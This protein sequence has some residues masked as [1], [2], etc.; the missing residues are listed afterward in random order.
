MPHDTAYR[1]ESRIEHE[2]I[3]SFDDFVTGYRRRFR[4]SGRYPTTLV[5][6]LADSIALLTSFGIGFFIVNAYDLDIINFK[7]FVSYWPYLPAFILGFTFAHLYPGLILA[8]AEEFRRFWI[9]S[10]MGHAGIVLTLYI[11]KGSMDAYTVAFAL[12]L[13][14]S[15]PILVLARSGTRRL[16]RGVPWWGIPVV[17]FGAGK[18]GLMLADRLLRHEWIG[19]RPAVILDDD[20]AHSGFYRGVPV[21]HGTGLGPRIVEQ[22]G[23]W[24]AIVAMPGVDRVRLSGIIVDSVR[25]FRHY[26]LIPDYFGMTNMWMSVR[27][28]DGILGLHTT[29]RLL[30]PTNRAMKRAFDIVLSLLLLILLAPVF[31][32]LAIAVRLD[33][34]GPVFYGHAR[35]GRNGTPFR[36]WKFRSM[37]RNA[38]QALKDILDRDARARAEWNEGFKLRKDPRITKIGAFLRR[39]SLDELPQLCNVFRGE[40]S[41][42]GPRPIVRSEIGRYS[43]FY[44]I[45]SGVRPGLSGLWQVSGRSETDYEERVAFDMYY[46]QSWSLWLDLYILFKTVGVVFGGKGAY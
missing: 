29:Q 19:Y 22:C 26:S 16:C 13:V 15:L 35:L 44:P 4:Y 2:R 40:M 23:I 34:P 33:S 42:I 14:A 8:P 10:S 32:I 11:Q 43:G 41:L 18:T 31:A 37:V 1:P 21:L 5:F 20:P 25:C 46:I 27:D 7:S 39:T 36:A 30:L 24:N 9:T 38:D 6:V 45:V 12:S 17:I 3:P 28:F